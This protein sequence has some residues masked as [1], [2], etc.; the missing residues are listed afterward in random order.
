MVVVWWQ[1]TM[2]AGRQNWLWLRGSRISCGCGVAVLLGGRIHDV[3]VMYGKWVGL[4]S[5]DPFDT[6][7]EVTLKI[8]KPTPG[9]LELN[10]NNAGLERADIAQLR[11]FFIGYPV[12]NQRKEVSQQVHKCK[13]VDPSRRLI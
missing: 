5:D 2:A 3:R 10:K 4:R 1:L 8:N 11:E 12:I 9:E 7:E 6:V 13:A